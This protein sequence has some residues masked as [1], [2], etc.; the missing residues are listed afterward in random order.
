M[1]RSLMASRT[2][3]VSWVVA[4]AGDVVEKELE[5]EGGMLEEVIVGLESKMDEEGEEAIVLLL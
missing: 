5:F 1:R 3:L 2:L 4:I